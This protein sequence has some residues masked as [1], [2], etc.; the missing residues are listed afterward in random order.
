MS[1]I[2][3]DG[4]R[5]NSASSDAITLASDGTCTANITNNLSNRNK[6]INGGMRI[7]QRQGDAV[8][9]FTS[10]SVPSVDRYHCNMSTDGGANIQRSADYPAGSGTNN[11]LLLTVTSADSSLASNQYMYLRQII[12]G[13]NMVDA[14]YGLSAAKTCTL[15]FWV[16][17]SVTGTF[18]GSVWNSAFNRSYPYNYTINS[19]NTWEKKVI[20]I[21]GDT[22]GTWLTD[23]GRGLSVGWSFGIGSNYVGTANQWNGSGLLAPTSHVNMLA[24]NGA[25]WRITAVQFEIGDYA[26]DF[27]HRSYGQ[28]L[29]L[30]QRYFYGFRPPSTLWRDGYSDTGI[31]VKGE[32]LFPVTMRAQPTVTL[33]GTMSH[34]NNETNDVA[35]E[36]P[37]TWITGAASIVRSAST[38]RTYSFWSSFSSQG[39]GFTFSAE[40]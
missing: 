16:K 8:T 3:V 10:N 15:S 33:G 23:N 35:S 12:E 36:T 34:S 40:L 2:K 22:S 39:Y 29:A 37:S 32:V 14:A 19:A 1:T 28:E 30:C 18:G 38:G 20:V 27:E 26:T 4:I 5:S 25:T 9:A 17:C 31:Y 24:T 6:I 11:S 13:N 7:N 21:P